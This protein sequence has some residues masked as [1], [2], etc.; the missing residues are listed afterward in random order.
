MLYI[1]QYIFYVVIVLVMTVIPFSGVLAQQR[2]NNPLVDAANSGN[3]VQV[4][5]FL[6]IGHHVDSR[7]DFGV[8][9]L[10]RAAFNGYKEII[11][12][13]INVGADIDAVD[14]GGATA[15]HVAARQGRSAVVRQLIQYGASV[16]VM[17]NEGWTPLMRAVSHKQFPVV[18]L[19]ANAGADF[20]KRNK[21]QDPLLFLAIRSG[22][23]NIVWFLVNGG[24]VDQMTLEEVDKAH[25]IA[26]QKG[27]AAIEQLIRGI[28]DGKLFKQAQ[29]MKKEPVVRRA[30]KLQPQPG[31]NPF[32]GTKQ[33]AVSKPD[34]PPVPP[35]PALPAV[36]PVVKS[37]P[38]PEIDR[39]MTDMP[40]ADIADNTHSVSEPIQKQEEEE[41]LIPD[42]I[43]GE[44]HM[45]TEEQA[46]DITIKNESALPAMP[47]EKVALE[48]DSSHYTLQLGVFER[49]QAAANYWQSLQEQ[50]PAL[51]FKISPHIIPVTQTSGKNMFRL[52]AGAF[53]NHRLAEQVCVVLTKQSIPC[54]A[55]EK[56]DLSQEPRTIQAEVEP[57]P[58]L[59]STPDPV[60]QAQKMDTVEPGIAV[61]K[62]TVPIPIFKT[63]AGF[64]PR[65]VLKSGTQLAAVPEVLEVLPER[66]ISNK[67]PITVDTQTSEVMEKVKG[68]KVNEGNEGL[69]WLQAPSRIT[70]HDIFAAQPEI[71]IS[72]AV[73]VPLSRSR[74]HKNL[75]KLQPSEPA[76][77]PSSTTMPATN[78]GVSS[79]YWA[80]LKGFSDRDQAN[81]FVDSV[82]NNHRPFNGLRTKIYQPGLL[83]PGQQE[84]YVRLGPVRTVEQAVAVCKHLKRLR[85][86][87]SICSVIRYVD[88]SAV[89]SPGHSSSYKRMELLS[90]ASANASWVQLGT[91]TSIEN[92]ERRWEYLQTHFAS[93]LGNQSLH[94]SSP[95]AK[96]D[97]KT[98]YRLRTGPF[99]DQKQAIA[100]CKTLVAQDIGCLAIK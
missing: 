87:P 64:V 18:Q 49:E 80:Q 68:R 86:I 58:W 62:G 17:D 96:R 45:D 35:V 56:K 79:P 8:T 57:L 66:A 71:K 27:N 48:K 10:M 92:L 51:F 6:E 33:L 69:P 30:P 39:H 34:V 77:A 4:S 81:I 83:A 1:K 55:L 84:A 50:F 36:P 28:R 14:I 95:A 5:H 60:M 76:S 24:V 23:Q 7:G 93:L 2:F 16:D 85:K 29:Y 88:S 61:V 97:G 67:Q 26:L 19:L 89:T 100:L 32:V 40:V 72:E 65:P 52:R 94:I 74:T 75:A 59:E 78:W 90:S 54:I 91:Y 13:L 38:V 42:T 37:V 43:S 9:P 73:R 99:E 15:L 70:P 22:D 12:M 82:V 53:D 11:D 41:L 21:R 31:V 98:L 44:N 63:L 47:V 25:Q 46:D 20:S 3:Y